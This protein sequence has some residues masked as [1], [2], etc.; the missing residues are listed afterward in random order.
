MLSSASVL[1]AAPHQHPCLCI[2][3]WRDVL[4]RIPPLQTLKYQISATKA[5]PNDGSMINSEFSPCPWVGKGSPVVVER[6][7][8]RFCAVEP[9]PEPNPVGTAVCQDTLGSHLRNAD[10]RNGS[11]SLP[12]SL[13]VLGEAGEMLWTVL[14]LAHADALAMPDVPD[15]HLSSLHGLALEIRRDNDVSSLS[16]CISFLFFRHKKK[17]TKIQT[18]NS[19]QRAGVRPAGSSVAGGPSRAP[20]TPARRQQRPPHSTAS[21]QSNR[22]GGNT[23]KKHLCSLTSCP[24]SQVHTSAWKLKAWKTPKSKTQTLWVP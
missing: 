13:S 18:N 8:G 21:V 6:T 7:P 4:D 14:F 24:D 2:T 23:K 9:P 17:N 11:P 10:G 3:A 20:E 19:T 5:F 16:F 12:P 22:E 15:A 1:G